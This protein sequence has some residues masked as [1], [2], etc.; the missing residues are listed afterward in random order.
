MGYVLDEGLRPYATER[1]WEML[2]ALA[3]HGSERK[4][5][6]AIGVDKATFNHV[7]RAVAKKA[8]QQGYAPQYDIT[9]EVPEGLTIR[10]TSIRYNG[11]GAIEQY[12]NKTKVQGRPDEEVV[13]ILD[14]KKITKTAT[15]YDNQGNVTQQWVSEKPE[16]VQR[17][18]LWIECAKALASDLPRIEPSTG[19]KHASDHL[20]AVYP[21]GDHHLGMLSW[22]QETGANYDLS[23]GETLLA[24]ATD[25]LLQATPECDRAAVVFL[26][27]LMH[28][29]SFE[30][31]TPTSRNMLD[32]D[33][34]YPK[35][36]RVA[37]RSM[38][39]L[40]EAAARRHQNVHVVVEIGNHDLSSSIFLMECLANIYEKEPR[41]T[42]DTSPMHYHYFDFGQCLV[43]TH[44]GH[45]AKMEQL[46]LIM[47]T[48]RREEWGRTSHR[49]WLTGHIHHRKSAVTIPQSQDYNGC[50]VESFRVLCP[51]DAWAAQKGY[52]AARDMKA[53]VLHKEFGEVARH[54]VNPEML[55]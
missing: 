23:I 41:I 3:I 42:I 21:V 30:A 26:G 8:A 13:H 10:G 35:M 11:E 54:T 33:G 45:G 5:A 36:V 29:D 44:H 2:T 46:P 20:M 18:A 51:P 24:G 6:K 16:D 27:D 52:R 15:L 14:P 37:I 28:Y 22:D 25:Y 48:D 9:H 55:G 4:A 31:I 43:G 7:K 32:A 38:R 39:Y 47:A 19:P 40:I 17:E 50:S 12:W 34:R 49:M 1:Q 53:L